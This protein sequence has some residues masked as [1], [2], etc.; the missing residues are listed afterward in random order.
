MVDN[1]RADTPDPDAPANQPSDETKRQ[2]EVYRS[3]QQFLLVT[4]AVGLVLPFIFAAQASTLLDVVSVTAVGLAIVLASMAMGGIFGFIFGVPTT[5]QG[6]RAAVPPAEDGARPVARSAYT[7]NTSLEQISDW[8]TKILVGVGL[9]Q[10]ASIPAGLTSVGSFLAAGLGGLPGADVFATV[11]FI[12]AVLNGFFLS[13]LWARLQL[14]GLFALSDVQAIAVDA[15]AAGRQQG[16]AQG[17]AKGKQLIEEQGPARQLPPVEAEATPPDPQSAAVEGPIRALW[18]DDN[19]DNNRTIR[20]VLT[21]YFNV[22]FDLVS[23]TRSAMAALKSGKDRYAF[24][25]TDM[26]RVGDR[27]AGYTLLREMKTAEITPPTIIY[28]AR[29]NPELEA[30]AKRRGAVGL[31]NTP[32]QLTDLVRKIVSEHRSLARTRMADR[33]THGPEA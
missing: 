3:A 19:P 20:Q 23:D 22:E 14:P 13:Y 7:G 12:F 1:A 9:T 5:L 27:S 30:E 24:V 25:I 16:Q 4:S 29:A 11:L 33:D 26:G 21:D 8:L 28:A 6:N 15:A 17:L 18:V 31:T 10:L 32:N 2:S